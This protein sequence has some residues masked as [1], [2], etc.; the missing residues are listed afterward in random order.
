MR[1]S[2][3]IR[4][5]EGGAKLVR[6]VRH[7]PRPHGIQFLEF[8]IGGLVGQPLQDLL[9]FRGKRIMPP[10]GDRQDAKAAA[11]DANRDQNPGLD[12]LLGDHP[13]FDRVVLGRGRT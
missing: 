1:L 2:T 8:G 13:G 5:R 4:G 9:R 3:D 12:A 7:E 6:H 11:S 10:S